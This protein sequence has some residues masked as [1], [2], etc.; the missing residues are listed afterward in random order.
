[1][2]ALAGAVGLSPR[3]LHRRVKELTGLTPG[4]YIRM[5]R[6]QRAEQL[7]RQQAGQV[8][9][10]AYAVGFNDAKYFSRLFRQTYGRAPSEYAA[11]DL[12]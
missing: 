1:V 7:L 3:Q 4:G 9:E 8:A 6:L 5:M 2:D 10:V 11:T 12:T